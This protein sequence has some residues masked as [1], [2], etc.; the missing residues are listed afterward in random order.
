MKQ[1]ILILI[2]GTLIYSCGSNGQNSAVEKA[3]QIQSA[4][5]PGT[6]ATAAGEFNMKAKIDGKTWE[7]A[8]MV[9]PGSAGR[10]VGYYNNDYIGLPYS[11]TD[12]VAGKKIV[13]N[14]DNAVDLFLNDGCLWTNPKGE[15]EITK[16]DGNS[17]EGKFFFT[18]ICSSKNKIIEVKEGLF[19][20]L[21]TK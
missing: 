15:I 9:N 21:I 1:P 14:E 12:L 18:I 3:K 20:I 8:S 17:A 7:A 16:A 13:I 2:I 6:I 4:I 19:R 5:K 11:K 10:I